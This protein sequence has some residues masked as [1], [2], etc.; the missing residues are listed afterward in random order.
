MRRIKAIYRTSPHTIFFLLASAIF[1]DGLAAVFT[2]GGIIA[3]GTFGFELPRTSSSSPSSATSWRPRAPSSAVPG[4]QGRAQGRDPRLPDRPA[5]RRDGDPGAGQRR[6]VFFG[7][8]WAGSTTF[9]VFGLFLCLFVGPAQSSSRA[10]LAR[11]APQ[12]ESGELFGLYATT[13]RAVSFLAPRCSRCASPWPHRWWPKGRPSAGHSGHHGGAPRRTAGPPP[14]EAPRA[15]PKSP[16]SRSPGTAAYR[17][18]GPRP[19]S[20]GRSRTRL[21]V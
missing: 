21:M 3:A 12:G 6:Y 20:P 13:G 15:R 18:G 7:T 5:G 1:R 9:W 2:F 4:R 10:Y 17:H 16:S 19:V 11:L 14:G 8:A